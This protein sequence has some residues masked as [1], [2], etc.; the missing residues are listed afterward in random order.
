[1][2]S[3]IQDDTKGDF[4]CIFILVRLRFSCNLSTIQVIRNRYGNDTVKLVRQFEKLDYNSRKL[5]LDLSFLENCIKN[6]VTPK[7]VQFR[8]T[9]RELQDSSAS[10]Q[11]QQKLL[12]Q[13]IVNKKRRVRLVKKD[14]SS[15]KNELMFKPKWMDFHHVCNLFLVM[16]I[17]FLNI[18]IFKIKNFANFLILL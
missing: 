13:E 5:L 12:K 6:N 16:I 14:L 3:A 9:N 10:R 8:F 4:Y 2:V 7:F 11:C 1:M 17:V 18:K 15:I